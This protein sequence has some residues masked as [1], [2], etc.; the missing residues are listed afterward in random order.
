[1]LCIDFHS[2][3]NCNDINILKAWRGL[4]AEKYERLPHKQNHDQLA[5]GVPGKSCYS[6]QLHLGIA[7]PEQHKPGRESV[8]H[9]PLGRTNIKH[10]L[11]RNQVFSII[12]VMLWT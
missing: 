10:R 1:M 7:A 3:K 12:Y 4:H 5:R 8:L 6:L 2:W 9:R 11:D